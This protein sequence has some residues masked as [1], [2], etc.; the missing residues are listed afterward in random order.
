MKDNGLVCT[1][2]KA[3]KETDYEIVYSQGYRVC[4]DCKKITQDS[5]NRAFDRDMKLRG[6]EGG[7]GEWEEY[8]DL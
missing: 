2:C 4:L 8:E 5:D 7:N 3:V 6:R 1:M